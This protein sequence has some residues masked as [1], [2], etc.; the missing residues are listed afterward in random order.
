M[1]FL[2]HA[3]NS[4]RLLYQLNYFLKCRMSALRIDQTFSIY[5]SFTVILNSKI[6][7]SAGERIG[8]DTFSASFRSYSF[9]RHTYDCSRKPSRS[10]RALT[11]HAA[12]ASVFARASWR[13]LRTSRAPGTSGTHRSYVSSL[14]PL[15]RFSLIDRNTIFL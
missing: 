4:V 2:M 5:L 6:K 12:L 10:C 14:S 1:P 9:L 15:A 7:P 11:A 13:T 8:P 3:F